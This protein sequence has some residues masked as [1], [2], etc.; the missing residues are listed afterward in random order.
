MKFL[1]CCLASHG[2]VYP[3]IGIALALRQRGHEVAFVT[4]PAFQETL[5]QVGIERIP[6]GVKDGL[7]FQVDTFIHPL[8]VMRQI[9]HI[10]YALKRFAADVLVGNELALGP[11]IAGK[12]FS[13]PVA[14]VGLAAYLLPTSESTLEL[15]QVNITKSLVWPYDE[16]MQIYNNAYELFQLPPSQV[17]DIPACIAGASSDFVN[18]KELPLLGDL[19]MLQSVPE[20]EGNVDA[21][22]PRVH[23]VGACLWE[24]PQTDIELVTWLQE[25]V[26]SSE[27]IIYV[28]HGKFYN[29]FWSC[30]IQSLKEQPLRVAAAV[31]RMNGEVGMI[32]S[33]FF[34]RHH[35]PQGLVL[36]YARAVISNGHTTP[37][38]GALTYGLPSLLF[39]VKNGTDEIAERCQY[40]G[41]AICLPPGAVSVETLG[42]AVQELLS[43]SKLR[44]NAQSLQS[45]FMKM[46]GSERAADLLEVLAVSRSPVLRGTI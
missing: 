4:S 25:S 8:F 27:P 11:L 19:F 40:A 44:Q 42:R 14:V 17:R 22:P 12:R 28:Q 35:I 36:R 2:F 1:F 41:A 9:G 33:N 23:L 46:N 18:H 13:L 39:P 29:S 45:A 24:L 16:M 21:L 6:C 10:E 43:S 7:S 34:V 15:A 26:T 37:V 20:L 30:L 5:A 3:A 31:G 38:L 32:S